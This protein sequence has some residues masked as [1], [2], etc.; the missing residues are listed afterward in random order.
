[1]GDPV[2]PSVRRVLEAAARKGVV[3]EIVETDGSRS[4]EDAARAVGT[5][6][7]R[8]VK[9]LVFMGAESGKPVLL[10][11][12]G[13]NRVDEADVGAHLGEALRR[14]AAEEVRA[15]TGFAIGGVSPFGGPDGL[16]ILMDEDLFAHPTVWA[17]GGTPRHVFEIVPLALRS[18]TSAEVLRVASE[19]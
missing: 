14:A 13:T 3:L 7:G 18:A 2:A 4:A 10:L 9:S 16:R 8:I 19:T 6:V 17:A 12:S 1:M 11:V 15:A 5:T